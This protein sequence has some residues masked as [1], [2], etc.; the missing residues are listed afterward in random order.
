MH[1]P[2][3]IIDQHLTPQLVHFHH[4]AGFGELLV[5]GSV[6]R[7]ILSRMNLPNVENV[8]I[9]FALVIFSQRFQRW[10]LSGKDGS[11]DASEL[12]DDRSLLPEPRQ[13]QFLALQVIDS[14]VDCL[15]AR[16]DFRF[17]RVMSIH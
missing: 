1:G 2:V 9:R 5:K 10:Y 13:A 3:Q 17:R 11:S 16:M 6:C 14:L 4:V 15:H 7:V 12:N 8:E